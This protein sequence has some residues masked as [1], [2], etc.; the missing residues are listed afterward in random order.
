LPEET[1]GGG[2]R[3]GT[4]GRSRESIKKK[5]EEG[6][7]KYGNKRVGQSGQRSQPIEE[8]ARKERRWL[9]LEKT[10][11]HGKEPKRGE[12][13]TRQSLGGARTWSGG[14]RAGGLGQAA[15]CNRRKLGK[16]L[17]VFAKKINRRGQRRGMGGT[18][19]DPW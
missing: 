12:K 3:G 16:L 15:I 8:G 7:W 18:R 5:P 19:A 1:V 17:F 11:H 10:Q 9:S 2:K 6:H 14:L 4:L 13:K